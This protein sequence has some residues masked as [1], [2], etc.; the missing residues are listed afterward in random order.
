MLCLPASPDRLS[1]F[2]LWLSGSFTLACPP[3][4]LAPLLVKWWI[5]GRGSKGEWCPLCTMPVTTCWHT[6]TSGRAPCQR[7][8]RPAPWG[9]AAKWQRST[10]VCLWVCEPGQIGRVACAHPD[11]RFNFTTTSLFVSLYPSVCIS[12]SHTPLSLLVADQQ[13]VEADWEGVQSEARQ[14]CPGNRFFSSTLFPTPFILYASFSPEPLERFD[15]CTDGRVEE[16]THEN[17]RMCTHTWTRSKPS[18]PLPW[19]ACAQTHIPCHM[20]IR[21]EQTSDK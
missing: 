18:P 15:K 4:P 21:V 19:R 6:W 9:H 2:L 7:G 11:R 13:Q 16:S 5:V 20:G 12:L 10:W 14:V 1:F 8:H 17:T 3:L